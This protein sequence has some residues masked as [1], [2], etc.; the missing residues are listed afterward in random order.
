MQIQWG[1]LVTR[2]PEVFRNVQARFILLHGKQTPTATVT[3][4]LSFHCFNEK[5]FNPIQELS[6]QYTLQSPSS[7]TGV[8]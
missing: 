8:H 7:M 5:L 3:P 1:F 2:S 4:E 6:R